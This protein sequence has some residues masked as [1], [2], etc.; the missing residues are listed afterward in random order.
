MPFTLRPYG[1]LPLAYCL[2]FWS[3]H[4]SIRLL[5]MTLLVLSS[6]PAYREWVQVAGNEQAGIAFAQQNLTPIL[7]H[8][9]AA[10]VPVPRTESW[11]TT[12]HE[13]SVKRIRQGEVDLLMIGDSI[14]QGWADVGRRIW[15]TYY[16]RRRAVNLGFNGDGTEHV[17]WRLDHGEIEGIAPKLVVVMIGTI[18]TG[19]RH[20]PPEETAA[21]IQAIL[22]TLHT[23][24]P[25]TKILL[26]GVF[27]RSASGDDL[28]RRLNAAINDRIRHYADNQQIFFLDL[29]PLFLD[30]WGR[31]A[32]DLMPDYLHPNERGYQVWADGM[33]DMIRKLLDE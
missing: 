26:L 12:Q 27:P 15:D 8:K 28:F 1:R 14:T 22:N 9:P 23:R 29:S 7:D 32:Q 24:L 11:W 33:E 10:V 2:G 6:V 20:D 25:G 31:V 13:D 3:S 17:L 21:G 5:V 30:G 4:R 19:T 16:G 18:N